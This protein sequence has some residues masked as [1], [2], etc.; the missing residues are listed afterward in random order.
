MNELLKSSLIK[1][2]GYIIAIILTII[3]LPALII[4]AIYR[5]IKSTDHKK[6]HK[7]MKGGESFFYKK[8]KIG[9]LLIHGFTSTP[10]ELEYLANFLTKKNISVM[11]PLLKGHGRSPEA[12]LETDLNDWI[13]SADKGYRE[14]KKHCNTIFIG[15]SSLGAN[16]AT[17]LAKKYKPDGLILLAMP[18][19]FSRELKIRLFMPS[20]P[21]IKRIKKTIKKAYLNQHKEIMEKKVHY[22]VLPIGNLKDAYELTKITR[23]LLPEIKTP[24]IV[25]QSDNDWQFGKSNAEYIYDNVKTKIKE[26]HFIKDSYHVFILDTKRD[27]AFKYI[28]NFMKKVL[29]KKDI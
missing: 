11:A 6:N 7:I 3:F 29:K 27:L 26:L 21:I 2:T 4:M 8:G 28:Y 1:S 23:E 5:R 12:M 9:V 18:A 17:I 20:F 19:Y 10:Q 22:K 16:I 25:I 14:L 13:K 24:T 15:G